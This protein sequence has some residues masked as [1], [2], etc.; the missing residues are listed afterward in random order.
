MKNQSSK[1]KWVRWINKNIPRIKVWENG[2][3]LL[4]PRA[5]DCIPPQQQDLALLLAGLWPHEKLQ[6]EFEEAL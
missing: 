3:R 5:V 1:C 4:H 2:L 6:S